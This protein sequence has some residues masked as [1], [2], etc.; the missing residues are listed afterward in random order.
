MSTT[1]FSNL[2]P[3]IVNVLEVVTESELGTNPD[4][5]KKLV[6]ASNT[7]RDDFGRAKEAAINLEGGDIS[8]E[9][10]EEIA[11]MLKGLIARKRLVLRNFARDIDTK[12][13]APEVKMD[14]DLDSTAS[15]PAF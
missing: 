5:K 11:E 9:E 15:T 6:Q 7:L 1:L 10:Q 8:L 2:L 12:A 13:A 3:N 14:I 4:L